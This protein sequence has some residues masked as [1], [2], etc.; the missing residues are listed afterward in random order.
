MRGTARA[1]HATTDAWFGCRRT[2]RTLVLEA[3]AGIPGTVFA[4]LHH[5]RAMR[6]RQDDPAVRRAIAQAD[7]EQAHL[8]VF[9]SLAVPTPFERAF[10][11]VGQAVLF[12]SFFALTVVSERA[13][14]RLS[15]YFEE[16][17]LDSYEDYARALERAEVDDA[18]IP[19]WAVHR[20][21]L[22]DGARLSDLIASIEREE[23][24]HRD[25]HHAAAD[26][27][28]RASRRHA[29]GASARPFGHRADQ[30]SRTVL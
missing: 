11:A 10:L 12:A 24:E 13:A 2:H 14:Q 21:Q 29:A 6:R 9:A 22:A 23:A 5:L 20:W 25:A 3:L 18:R 17:A 8:M 30:K 15:G 1:I 7:H 27:L 19:R 4:V 28:V 16:E 26:A